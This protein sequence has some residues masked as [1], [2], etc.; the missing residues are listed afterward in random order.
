MSHVDLSRVPS[1]YHRY[2]QRTME[3]DLRTNFQKHLTGILPLLKS[4]PASKWDHRY[5][6]DKW[7]I[8]EMVLH[9]SDAERIF[10]YRALCF[11]RK[12]ATPLPGFEEND[13]VVHSHASRRSPESLMEELEGVQASTA[14]LFLSF[15]DEQLDASG[16]ANG[17]SVYVK[18]IAYI[19]TG[20]VLHH[21]AVLEERYL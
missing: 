3:D 14:Q 8:R 13:Y 2:V 19:V 6:A 18:G 9:L 16:V 12:D 17:N 15:D 4:L 20:H 11:A 10:A 1:F 21:K 5:A 7:T